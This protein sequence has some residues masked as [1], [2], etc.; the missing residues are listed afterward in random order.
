MQILMTDTARHLVHPRVADAVIELAVLVLRRGDTAAV[1]VPCY[2]RGQPSTVRVLLHAG[3]QLV[4]EP[5][6]SPDRDLDPY[7][8]A[9]LREI[10]ARGESIAGGVT[11]RSE[12]TLEECFID[13]DRFDQ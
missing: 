11:P 6:D 7:S 2:R 8:L 4:V 10:T 9:L 3:T 12:P 13:F 1:T 5:D